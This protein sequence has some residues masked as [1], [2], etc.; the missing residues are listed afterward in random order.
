MLEYLS[1]VVGDRRQ[2]LVFIG[3][4]WERG[5]LRAA[6]EAALLPEA[7]PT[8]FLTPAVAADPFPKWGT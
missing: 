6:L 2:E 7:D 1:P 8:S 5:P 3:V 4:N